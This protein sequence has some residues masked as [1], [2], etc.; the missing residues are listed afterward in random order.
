MTS[1]HVVAFFLA[2]H[3]SRWLVTDVFVLARSELQV[4]LITRETQV[5]SA[6]H[7]EEDVSSE[8]LLTSAVGHTLFHT[9]PHRLELSHDDLELLFAREGKST[10]NSTANLNEGRPI[11]AGRF[12]PWIL[13][14]HRAW[15]FENMCTVFCLLHLIAEL[16]DVLSSVVL[17]SEATSA[18]VSQFESSRHAIAV[19]DE[20]IDIFLHGVEV[21]VLILQPS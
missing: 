8:P 9:L 11:R 17:I 3:F 21:T 5:T 15:S 13:H 6:S 19:S 12:H 1:P 16:L 4:K 10:E 2:S 20:L 14:L 18:D 7:D